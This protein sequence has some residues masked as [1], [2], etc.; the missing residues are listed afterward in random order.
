[1]KKYQDAIKRFREQ[2]KYILKHR[3]VKRLNQRIFQ[4]LDNI[5]KKFKI[6]EKI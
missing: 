1:M 4:T 3:I 2:R 6:E 5:L